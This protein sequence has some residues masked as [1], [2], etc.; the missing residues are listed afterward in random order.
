MSAQNARQAA[1]KAKRRQPP[2]AE[3]KK[4][5]PGLAARQRAADLVFGVLVEGEALDGAFQGKLSADDHAAAD[6]ALTQALVLTTLRRLPTLDHAINA[7]L[8]KPLHASAAKAMAILRVMA[9]QLLVL[10]MADH[11]AVTL[12]VE[13]AARRKDARKLKGLIN[14]VGRRM[15]REKD[16]LLAGTPASDLPVWLTERWTRTY[17]TETVQRIAGA[18][19]YQPAIDLTLKPDADINKWLEAFAD[20]DPVALNDRSIRL[21]KP[22]GIERLPGYYDGVWWVQDIA[23]TLPA[24]ILLETLAKPGEARVLDLCAAPG[25]KTAQLASAGCKVTSVDQSAPRMKRLASNMTRLQ[26]TAD[27]QVADA[28]A[29]TAN[30]PFDAVLLDAPCS[31]TGTLRRNPDIG[32]LRQE[33][34]VRA[35]AKLQADLLTHAATLVTPGGVLVFATCSLEPE[36]GEAQIKRFLRNHE[37]W[38][39][40]PVDPNLAPPDSVQRDETL[41]TLPH[42]AANADGSANGMDGFFAA[43]LR[44][45]H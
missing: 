21:T 42:M 10:D 15:V 17:G 6:R 24:R 28:L 34:D 25:G 18:M 38:A 41:R 16:T 7:C 44:A 3:N 31:A 33:G 26:L 19:R 32:Y 43:C 8:D 39:L 13:D 12:A 45:P 30:K 11:A 2:P 29:Y 23:A 9:A 35:L 20:H 27:T 22:G 1:N 37:G 4:P 40:V 5:I 36:E 14:A